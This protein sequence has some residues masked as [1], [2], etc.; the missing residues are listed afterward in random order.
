M[1]RSWKKTWGWVDR[2]PYR[3]NQANKK[4]RKTKNIPNGK[5]YKKL[6]DSW[7]ISDHRYLEFYRNLGEYWIEET[8]WKM[9]RK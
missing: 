1:S 9:N 3:K 8:P 4:V 5:A 6:Y 2:N 7:N